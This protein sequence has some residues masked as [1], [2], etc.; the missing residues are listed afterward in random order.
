MYVH[1]QVPDIADYPQGF[2]SYWLKRT[3][4]NSISTSYHINA[5]ATT[6]VRLVEAALTEYR[7]GQVKL[8]EFWNTHTSLN[9]SAMHRS[10]SHFESCLFNMNRAINCFTRLRR[11]KDLPAAL[12][13]TLDEERPKFIAD[14]VASQIRDMRNAVHHL[15]ERVMD[16]R[17]AEGENFTLRSD[18]PEAPHATEVGQTNKTVDRLVIGKQ[19]IMFSDLATWLVEMAQFA[20]RLAGYEA[21]REIT[22]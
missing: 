3:F 16:G 21:P 14:A 8:K 6:Y 19:E 1:I 20:D 4:L 13:Q 7:L 10:I 17:I 11:H 5:L 15:E 2:P 18:G 22:P 9:L 12:Q